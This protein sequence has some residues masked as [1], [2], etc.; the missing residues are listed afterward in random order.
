M[1]A[2]GHQIRRG[3]LAT[4]VWRYTGLGRLSTVLQYIALDLP[5]TTT[6]A[7]MAL[8]A[9][10][11]AVHAYLIASGTADPAYLIAYRGLI[12]AGSSSAAMLMSLPGPARAGWRLGSAV[13]V[14]AAA[15][16]LASRTAGLPGMPQL[17]GRWDCPLGTVTMGVAALFLVL[18]GSVLAGVNVAYPRR[19]DWYD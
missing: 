3:P 13:S 19:R 9:G 6:A 12:V 17:A 4:I 16:Y 14:V 10:L 7:G 18:H 2:G 11:T 5:R 1:A 15:V 8:M